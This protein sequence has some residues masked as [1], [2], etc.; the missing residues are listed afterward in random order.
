MLAA[1]PGSKY[2]SSLGRILLPK[3]V[4]G[5]SGPLNRAARWRW[6]RPSA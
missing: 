1:R 3:R 2:R 6:L 4:P 5:L